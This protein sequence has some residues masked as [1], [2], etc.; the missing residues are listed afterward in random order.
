MKRPVSASFWR[1]LSI[2][3]LARSQGVQPI[4]K[5]EETLGGWPQEEADDHFEE[6]LEHWRAADVESRR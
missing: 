1:P 4:R 2:E 3:Q 6:A 5:L